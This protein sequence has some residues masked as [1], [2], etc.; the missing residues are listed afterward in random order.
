[1][2]EL[3]RLSELATTVREQLKEAGIP[4]TVVFSGLGV[5]VVLDNRTYSVRY[6]AG[7]G[8]YDIQSTSEDLGTVCAYRGQVGACVL[9]LHRM[10]TTVVA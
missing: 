2:P 7:A 6:N 8:V 4:A 5:H 3:Q 10:S 1:M 9:H